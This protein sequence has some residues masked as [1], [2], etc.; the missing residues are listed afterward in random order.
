ME[1]TIDSAGR[2]VV[3]KVLRDLLG[4]EPGSKVDVS[5]YGA[6]LQL[7]PISRTARLRTSGAGVVADSDTAIT[8]DDIFGLIDAGRR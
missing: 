5:Q 6:G 4:L 8:D 2:L 3:P 7:L 1:T